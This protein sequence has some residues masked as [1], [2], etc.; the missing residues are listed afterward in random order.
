MLRIS[1]EDE[2]SH[3]LLQS[4]KICKWILVGAWIGCVS[5]V[6]LWYR[7]VALP[8]KQR[9]TDKSCAQLELVSLSLET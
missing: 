2:V 8:S 3:N 1:V 4:V 5:F 6:L 9:C 7:L